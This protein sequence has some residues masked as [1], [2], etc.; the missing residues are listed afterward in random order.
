VSTEQADSDGRHLRRQRNRAAVV[1]ALLELY[2][3]G[4]LDPSS[5]EIAER[6]GLSPRS[7]F[8]Y[9][10]DVD[11][12]CHEAVML[13]QRA[14]MPLLPI[15]ADASDPLPHRVDALIEQR[16]VLFVA[17]GNVGRV[18][19][20]RAPFLPVVATELAAARQFL[21]GQVADLFA[22]ELT[23][24]GV[25]TGTAV[26]MAVDALTSFEANELFVGDQ[27]LEPEPVAKN[28]QAVLLSLVGGVPVA[29]SVESLSSAGG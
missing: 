7:L 18:A 23:A 22:P 26:L 6:A 24:M 12:L 5:V 16:R 13:R 10:D 28:L 20:L 17:M 29:E 21:R 1:E 9:F 2:A 11:D 14:M 19:R 4:S 8:R 3:E 25:A 27:L 15:H